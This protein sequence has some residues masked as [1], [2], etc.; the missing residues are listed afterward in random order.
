MIIIA[1]ATNM[2]LRFDGIEDLEL[3]IKNLT[4]MAQW[5]REELAEGRIPHFE[6]IMWDRDITPE[7]REKWKEKFDAMGIQYLEVD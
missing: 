4:H 3:Q 6:Y 7:R 2:A 5:C 1:S